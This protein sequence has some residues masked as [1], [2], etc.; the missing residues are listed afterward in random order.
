VKRGR[1]FLA[2]LMIGGCAPHDAKPTGRTVVVDTLASTATVPFEAPIS[3]AL[4][5]DGSLAVVDGRAGRIF[6][7]GVDGRLL[8]TIGAPGAGPAELSQPRAIFLRGDTLAVLNVGNGRVENFLADGT[9][10]PSRPL[11]EHAMS[12]S[13]VLLRG[14]TA[15]ITTEGRDSSLAQLIT[16]KGPT[17]VRY[18]TS[19]VPPI[20]VWDFT[21]MKRTIR[22]GH[23]PAEMRNVVL[24]A[25]GPAGDVWLAV[26]TEGRI[27][28]FDRSGT[29]K[30]EVV[31]AESDL[32]PIRAAFVK[33]NTDDAN[34]GRLGM[35]ALATAGAADSAGAWFMLSDPDTTRTVLLRVNRDGALA[36]RLEIP[37]VRDARAMTW[38]PA[39]ATFYLLVPAEGLVL[40]CRVT[41]LVGA[42]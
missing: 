11:P 42:R 40:R 6:V 24:P 9:H 10:G 38:D 22:E 1:L 28:H 34:P 33:A 4:L 30:G 13:V 2:M 12:E 32:A 16:R 20:S 14:D 18:G 39:H 17:G 37:G 29:L 15:L 19:V 3:A 36:D 8:R 26:Q 35:Y 7:L 41:G 5:P 27:Q 23:V 21:A 25:I 31:V